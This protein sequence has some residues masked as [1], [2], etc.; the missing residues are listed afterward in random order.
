MNDQAAYIKSPTDIRSL[1]FLG[2]AAVA[3]GALTG[4]IG[5]AFRQGLVWLDEHR[6]ASIENLSQ[7]PAVGWIVPVIASGL[8]VAI[9]RYL[10][11]LG[12]EAG[13]SGVQYVEASVRK[14]IV[15]SRFRTIPIKFFGGLLAIGSGLALGRE[16]PT[17]QMGATIGSEVA[18]K[19]RLTE[20]DQ[21]TMQASAAGAGLAVAFNAPLGGSV[22]VLEELTKSIRLR[23]AIVTLLAAGTAVAVM[24]LIIGN[25]PDYSVGP[26]LDYAP[27]QLVLFFV[28]GLLAGLLSTYYNKT[29]IACIAIFD[30]FRSI[31]ILVRAAIVG[32]AVGLLCWFAPTMA[33]GGDNITQNILYGTYPVLLLVGIL[34]LR[35]F[36][37]SVSYSV[38]APGGL[39][40]P[41]LVL[42]AAAG[43]IFGGALAQLFPDAGI[44]PVSFALVGMSSFFVGVVRTPL[45]GILLVVEM[46]AVSSQVIP[47]MIAAVG[48]VFVTTLLRSEPIYDTLRHQ[49]I[50]SRNRHEEI[51]PALG[52]KD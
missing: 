13:G 37:G 24:R 25:N 2:I 28:F 51:N 46:T 50:K 21:L 39:F 29:V 11:T 18:D 12:P 10:V 14:Q 19:M 17:V 23:L 45:T 43:A 48:V 15:P 16:G 42:G 1:V 9:A 27:W 6:L 3:A 22:F 4:V 32:A 26:N 35:W 52:A 33:G 20:D 49:L 47:M 40:A 34:I 36:L 8:A 30:H 31:P 41:L 44:N 38:G 5:A 7:W